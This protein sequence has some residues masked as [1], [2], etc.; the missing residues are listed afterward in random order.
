M[1]IASRRSILTGLVRTLAL[2]AGPAIVRASALMPVVPLWRPPRGRIADF[3][4]D[5]GGMEGM[6]AEAAAANVLAMER[7]TEWAE[8]QAGATVCMSPGWY[9]FV[10]GQAID[11]GMVELRPGPPHDWGFCTRIPRFANGYSYNR[12][13]EDY[14]TVV[15]L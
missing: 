3:V 13:G 7:I 11:L 4:R 9:N 12:P 2:G 5:F 10:P 6:S 8:R 14:D 1:I 15:V